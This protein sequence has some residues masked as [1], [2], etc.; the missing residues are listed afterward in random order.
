MNYGMKD[1]L[2]DLYKTRQNGYR[3]VL[4]AL[5]SSEE[6]MRDH[7]CAFDDLYQA[8]DLEGLNTEYDPELQ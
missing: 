3:S 6:V 1:A 2:M 4:S 7:Q 5:D 8:V